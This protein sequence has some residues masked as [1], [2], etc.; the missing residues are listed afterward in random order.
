MCGSYVVPSGVN[1]LLCYCYIVIL[2]YFQVIATIFHNKSE[3]KIVL[4]HSGHY[5]CMY[6]Y[7]YVYD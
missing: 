4:K 2:L 1:Y 3:G 6:A 7:I 5:I